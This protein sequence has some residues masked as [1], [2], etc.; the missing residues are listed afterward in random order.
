M[1]T[2]LIAR[3]DGLLVA[4]REGSGAWRTDLR[5]EKAGPRCVASDPADGRLYCGTFAQGLWRSIDGGQS[6]ERVGDE[7]SSPIL[8]A[9]AVS[10]KE[11]HDGH[12]VVYAGTEPSAIYRSEDGGESWDACPGLED[13]PSASSWSFPPRPDTH[14]VEWIACDPTRAGRLWAAIEAGALIRSDDGG[15]SWEDRVPE[16]P[17]DTHELATHR[18]APGRLYSAAGDGYFESRD[19]GQTWQSPEQ[20]LRESYLVSVAVDS[21]DPETILVSA[22]PGPREAYGSADSARSRVYRRSGGSDW[23]EVSEGLPSAQGR[24]AAV[25]VSD[26]SEDGVF[27]AAM[28][29]GVF[30]SV[31]AG[32]S[33]ERQPLDW[34]PGRPRVHD[35]ALLAEI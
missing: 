24:T 11:V 8:T 23:E 12:G 9:V 32:L 22:A 25:L 3:E 1:L 28:N 35:L 2:L 30:R 17:Y 14:H 16:G 19:G 15:R 6:W 33:W 4:R 31:D 5:L 26:P 20:G 13:L 29:H 18:S 21:S 10:L 34:P 7:N 27:H